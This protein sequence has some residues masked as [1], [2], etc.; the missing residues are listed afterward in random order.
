MIT[1]MLHVVEK[2][3][4]LRYFVHVHPSTFHIMVSIFFTVENVKQF[5]KIILFIKFLSLLHFLKM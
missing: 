2:N 3:F 1:Q 4:A 5:V